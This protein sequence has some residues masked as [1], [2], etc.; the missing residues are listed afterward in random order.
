[1]DLHF[2]SKEAVDSEEYNSQE[3][4]GIL[5]EDIYSED[6]SISN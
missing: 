2:G 5:K 4:E 3:D 1:M 6:N